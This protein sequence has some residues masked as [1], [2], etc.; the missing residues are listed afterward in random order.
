MTGHP[1]GGVLSARDVT[2]N[3]PAAREGHAMFVSSRDR[4]YMGSVA[5]AGILL[6]AVLL[7]SLRPKLTPDSPTYLALAHQ[8]GSLNLVG[9]PG[10][11]TPGYPLLLLA[12]GY[13]QTAAWIVQAVLGLA[14]SLLIYSLIRRLGGSSV[15][16]LLGAAF[17]AINL[18]VVADER[19]V[20]TETLTSFLLVVTTSIWLHVTQTARPSRRAIAGLG[21]AL[22]YLCL[23]RPDQL[24]VALWFAVAF[25]LWGERRHQG[26][27]VTFGATMKRAV[28]ALLPAVIALGAW[29][30]INKDTT[31]VFTVSTVAGHNM[32]DHVA[33]YVRVEP[34]SDRS[35]ETAYVTVRS[36]LAAEGI[37]Y[38]VSW[39]AEP[40]MERA[41]GLMAAEVSQRLLELACRPS[42][43][44]RGLT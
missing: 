21:V 27:A 14:T 38:N 12:L 18:S 44:I 28:A 19:Q 33:P 25:V 7:A 32:I 10:I 4:W 40:A 3:M 13:S 36:R 11:R 39:A 42:Q 20:M 41:S 6:R 31:G 37:R 30:G 23:T 22:A 34:G 29:A 1:E 9:N 5:V 8:I 16:A 17:Y 43:V 35:I 2:L 24:V 15:S 26:N